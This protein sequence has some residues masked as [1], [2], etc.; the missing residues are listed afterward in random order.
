[1]SFYP[2][3]F[4]IRSN[5]MMLSHSKREK[6]KEKTKCV[7]HFRTPPLYP[8]MTQIFGG[9]H[10]CLAS[11]KPYLYDSDL[12]LIQTTSLRTCFST[13][14]DPAVSKCSIHF[15][16][17]TPCTSSV[18]PFDMAVGLAL[19]FQSMCGMIATDLHVTHVKGIFFPR[20]LT[21]QRQTDT[22][23]NKARNSILG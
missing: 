14:A 3:K 18:I 2:K 23:V 7:L 20:S 13:A 4:N 5:P 6:E 12:G 8:E 19:S 15:F 17:P 9:S 22:I 1:M 10:S 16:I 11:H 21:C